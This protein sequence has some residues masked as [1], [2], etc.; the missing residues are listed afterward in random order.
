LAG[1]LDGEGCISL[2]GRNAERGY[3][4]PAI[5]VTNTDERLIDWLRQFGG[6]V[7]ARHDARVTRKPSWTWCCFG[8]VA[9][10]LLVEVEPYLKL[11]GEQARLVLSL[12]MRRRGSTS[13]LTDAERR[14]RGEVLAS[15][16]DLNRRGAHA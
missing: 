8:A 16:R 14:Q 10:E 6:R 9:R 5:Q 11:K 1:I 15:M 12:N 4:T 2:H 13:P 3:L 7:Y